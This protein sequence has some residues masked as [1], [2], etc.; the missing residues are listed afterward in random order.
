MRDEPYTVSNSAVWK[1]GREG[2]VL[3]E[4]VVKGEQIGSI[5]TKIYLGSCESAVMNLAG[6]VRFRT[7]Q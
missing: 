5:L 4:G 7:H 6:V 1:S 3:K 2:G